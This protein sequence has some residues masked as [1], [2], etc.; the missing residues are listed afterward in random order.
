MF[1]KTALALTIV[2]A[3]AAGALAATKKQSPTQTHVTGQQG[4]VDQRN[5]AL[6]PYIWD[7]GHIDYQLFRD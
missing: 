1:T 2:L 3:T 7:N 5:P 6:N 4:Q